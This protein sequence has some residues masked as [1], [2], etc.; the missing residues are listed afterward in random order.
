MSETLEYQYGDKTIELSELVS[1]LNEEQLSLFFSKNSSLN[2]NQK[3]KS[4][5][6]KNVKVSLGQVFTPPILAGFMS[7]LI[8]KRIKGQSAILDPCIGPNTFFKHFV[9]LASSHNLTGIELDSTLISREI[10]EFYSRTN[11][12]LIKGSFFKL[13]LKRKFDFII[14]NPPYV[15]QELMVEGDNAKSNAVLSIAN[16]RNIIPS[17]SNLYVYFL[18]KSILHLNEGGRLVAVIYDS[19]LYSSFGK[20]LK[21]MFLELGEL[22]TIYHFRHNA[23]PEAE[24]GATVIDFVRTRSISSQKQV[25]YYSLSSLKDIQNYKKSF[26]QEKP[27]CIRKKQFLSWNFNG[28]SAVNFNS[29]F[30]IPLN[31][32]TNQPIQRGISSLANKYFIH[33]D[34]VFPECKPLIKDVNKLKGYMVSDEFSYFLSIT[35]SISEKTKEYLNSIKQEISSND[36]N[37]K[38]LKEKIKSSSTWYKISIKKP[39]NFVFNYY[40]RSNI[41]FIH[42]PKMEYA[43]DNFYILNIPDEPKLLLSVLNSTFSRLSILR[44]SR[45]QGHG[46]RKIQLYEFKKVSIPNY[47]CFSSKTISELERLG[48]KL[49]TVKRYSKEPELIIKD[50]DQVIISEYNNVLGE[51]LSIADIHNELN[52]LIKSDRNG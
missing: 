24:V 3:Q 2:P 7:S 47:K 10:K 41:D 49:Q 29:N 8:K 18:L 16:M 35:S 6:N 34:Q 51:N 48:S 15:R 50:I 20:F 5:S 46:L 1:I 14:Q 30:F 12:E 52:K 38:A 22:E 39:G 9:E 13:P 17:K 42:N 19:W 37:F 21:K 11:N 44:H 33:S 23:F 31:S 28:L 36:D 25:K 4:S 26:L 27:T 45:S 43:S 40:L 32:L